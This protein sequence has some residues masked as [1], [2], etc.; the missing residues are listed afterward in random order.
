MGIIEPV[1]LNDPSLK[2][3]LRLVIVM[4]ANGEPR[5]TV[6]LKRL[7]HWCLGSLTPLGPLWGRYKYLCLP[8]GLNISGDGYNQRMSIIT[9]DFH[10]FSMRMVDNTCI[11][12]DTIQGN[13][14][15]TGG[16]FSTCNQCGVTFSWK[17]SSFVPRRCHTLGSG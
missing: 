1:G 11:H 10:D 4:K 2:G 8:Q 5:G 12:Q 14:E 17:S 7:I 16:Y 13:F 9:Q 15:S 3:C 6:N